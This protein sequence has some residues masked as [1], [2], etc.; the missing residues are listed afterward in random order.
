MRSIPVVRPGLACRVASGFLALAAVLVMSEAGASERTLSEKDDRSTVTLKRGEVFAVRLATVPGTGYSWQVTV[1]DTAY[2]ERVSEVTEAPPPARAGETSH[3]V[4]R[5][6]ARA[7]GTTGL[8]LV[9]RRV[10]EAD[11]SKQKTFR[12]DV[13]INP[14]REGEDA[15]RQQ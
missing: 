8:E 10:W 6:R 3:R 15:R 4:L 14:E 11:G 12:V 1:C 2:L 5:L 13:V 7:A 9:Y